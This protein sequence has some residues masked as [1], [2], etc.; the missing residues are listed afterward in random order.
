[1]KI[2]AIIDSLIYDQES[3]SLLYKESR[4]LLIRPE[5][6]IGFQKAIEE[7]LKEKADE[8]F[9]TGGFTGGFLSTK[10][11]KELHSYSD[12]EIID[13][14]MKMGAE[15]G[16]GRFKLEKYDRDKKIL[17][18]SVK[19]SPFAT[20]Y[21]KADKGVCHLTRGVMAGMGSAL[22]EQ[23]CTGKEIACAAKGDERCVFVIKGK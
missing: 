19:D 14:M 22:F 21:G 7:S 12:R 6:I 11:Y 13:F 10:K 9:Y 1:M 18:V 4:Y 17:K 16:W 5:T 3:G 23:N 8:K 20:A 15:I 2:N